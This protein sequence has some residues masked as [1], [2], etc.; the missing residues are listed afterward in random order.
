MDFY[1]QLTLGAER[2]VNVRQQRALTQHQL[3]VQLTSLCDLFG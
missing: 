1:A 3:D 2:P